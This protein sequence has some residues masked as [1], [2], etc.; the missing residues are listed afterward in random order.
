MIN[1]LFLVYEFLKSFIDVGIKLQP[2][3]TVYESLVNSN[4]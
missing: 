4:E 3:K 1:V 2:N